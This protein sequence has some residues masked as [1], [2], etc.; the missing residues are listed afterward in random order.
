M[1]S[2]LLISCSGVKSALPN[3]MCKLPC[4]SSRYSTLPPLKSDTACMTA[5]QLQLLTFSVTY[6]V[7]MQQAG[8]RAAEAHQSEACVDLDHMVTAS[9]RVWVNGWQSQQ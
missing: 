7:F 6:I 2:R 8:E 1:A 4:L 9:G 5:L 3:G